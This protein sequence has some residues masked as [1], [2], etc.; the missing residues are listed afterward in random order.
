[1]PAAAALAVLGELRE[2]SSCTGADL[3]GVAEL[4]RPQQ[5]CAD[6]IGQQRCAAMLSTGVF[7]C[8]TEFCSGA[9]CPMASQC[10]ST[11]GFC[12]RGI[13][14]AGNGAGHRRALQGDGGNGAATRCD[15]ASFAALATTVTADCCDDAA[16][17]CGGGVA[18]SCDAKCGTTYVPFF[19]NC[20]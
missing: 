10:D 8:A 17:S 20:R 7:S 6:T 4:A 14:G 3:D 12:S 13:A 16:G 11:C 9:E 5:L 2:T 15:P 18:T 19:R 1:M